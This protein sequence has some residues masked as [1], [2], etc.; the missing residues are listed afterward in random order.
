MK[1][2]KTKLGFKSVMKALRTGKVKA[3]LLSSNLPVIRKSELE[4]LAVLAKVKTISF[5][6]TNSELGTACGKLFRVSCM[7]IINPGDSDILNDN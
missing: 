7:A 6:G 4:Y 5:S 2:G 1:S 3:L